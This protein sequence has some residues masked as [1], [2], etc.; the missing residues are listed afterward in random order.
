MADELQYPAKDKKADAA[1]QPRRPTRGG[2]LRAEINGTCQKSAE[3]QSSY[4]IQAQIK[5]RCPGREGLVLNFQA[6]GLTLL[7]SNSALS[8]GV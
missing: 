2:N 8:N 4:Q 6:T 3:N 5:Q 7:V 1:E